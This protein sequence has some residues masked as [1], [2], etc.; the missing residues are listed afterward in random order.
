[1]WLLVESIL[2]YFSLIV[3]Y[4]VGIY[5]IFYND[6]CFTRYQPYNLC[7]YA[8]RMKIPFKTCVHALETHTTYYNFQIWIKIGPH[9][10]VWWGMRLS[11]CSWWR[12]DIE[13]RTYFYVTLYTYLC[14]H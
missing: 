4:D 6:L 14:Q 7:N 8:M 13:S 10:F 5:A 3:M 12:D 1:M 11:A 9:A 2:G